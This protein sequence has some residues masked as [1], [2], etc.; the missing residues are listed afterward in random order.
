[1]GVHYIIKEED[2]TKKLACQLYD[3]SITHD[4]LAILNDKYNK[5][6]FSLVDNHG[7]S[8]LK[9]EYHSK[10]CVE[11]SQPDFLPTT[12][13]RCKRKPLDAYDFTEIQEKKII[14]TGCPYC[15]TSFVS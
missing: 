13:Y 2:G 15:S 10:N 3:L 1:M 6:D 11:S 14:L 4:I 7:L 9:A 8:K 5:A 12:C